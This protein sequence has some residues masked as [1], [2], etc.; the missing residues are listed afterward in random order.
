MR[1]L[2]FATYMEVTT[3]HVDPIYH[4]LGPVKLGSSSVASYEIAI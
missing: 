4:F 3:D 1:A 2:V